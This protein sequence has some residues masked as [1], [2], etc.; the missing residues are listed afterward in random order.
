MNLIRDSK[1]VIYLEILVALIM[2][3][4]VISGFLSVF[5]FARRI[6]VRND[7]KLRAAI[8]AMS[9]LEM[10]RDYIRMDSW[11]VVGND[12]NTGIVVVDN[13]P[14]PPP[15]DEFTSVRGGQR[16]FMV[17]SVPIPGVPTVPP[18]AAAQNFQPRRVTV[19]ITW[20]GI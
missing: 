1:A 20:N 12:L 7:L 2:L 11:N 10:F 16:G 13:V 19:W 15:P 17:G 6:N 8:F 4:I 9:R 14:L 3:S 18:A 5:M